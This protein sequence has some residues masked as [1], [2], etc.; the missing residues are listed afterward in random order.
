MIPNVVDA[1]ETKCR[2]KNNSKKQILHVSLLKDDIKNVSGIIEAIKDLSMKRD[3]EL[4]IVGS[5]VDREML[6]ILRKSM[7]F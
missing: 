6:E 1:T 4:H 5:G 3:F 2:K 7:G